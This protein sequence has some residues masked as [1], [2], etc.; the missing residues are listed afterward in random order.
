M[1]STLGF[2]FGGIG[3]EIYKRYEGAGGKGGLVFGSQCSH[4][5]VDFLAQAV[6]MHAVMVMQWAL[7]NN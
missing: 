5:T 1:G 4:D 7:T 6:A 2:F 3:Y